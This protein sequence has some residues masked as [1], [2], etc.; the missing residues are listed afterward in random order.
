MANFPGSPQN[1]QLVEVNGVTYR[2]NSALA[3]WFKYQ[4]TTANVVTTDTANI[5]STITS[6]STTTGALKVA[7]GAGIAGNVF[8]GA[9][10]TNNL[11]YA[12]GTTFSGGTG[13]TGS[14]G[15]GFTGS[16]GTA[17]FTGS[18]GTNGTAGFT[19]SAGA[20][21][22]G[23]AGS[24]GYAGSQGPIG[25]TGSAA[26]GGAGNGYTGSQGIPGTLASGVRVNTFT[27]NAATANG[28]ILNFALTEAPLTVNETIVAIDGIVQQRSTYTINGRTLTLTD[29]LLTTETMEV[30]TMVY[31]T[32]NFV[33]R[34][35]TGNGSATAYTVTNGVT[36]NSVVVT[37]NGVVQAPTA[38]YTI[39]GNVLTFTTAPAAGVAIGI[40]EIPAGAVGFTGSAGG[41][42]F[43]GSAGVNGFTGSAGVNGFTGSAG[44]NGFTGSAGA[45]S[46]WS[47]KTANYTAISGDRIIADTT[48]GSFVISLPATPG[49]GSLVKITDGYNFAVNSLTIGAN[50]STIESQA[51]DV[52]VDI[53]KIDL[54]FIYDGSTWQII[55]TMGPKGY[56]GS[57]GANGA[58]GFTGSQG[59]IGY[60]GSSGTGGSGDSAGN[61]RVFGY[62]MIFGG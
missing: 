37:E 2:Y 20:G 7:G 11:F 45:L 52:V 3:A 58:N 8:A 28:S 49:L 27:G 18:A 1:A 36:V 60:T 38:D 9:V 59:S 57:A 30:T 44:V 32:A 51:D 40:R 31:G 25:Y 41:T 29:P 48:A 17:G 23:S 43:T 21:F 22:T 15:T 62:T 50:G 56:A 16:S 47:K 24:I 6:T 55:S 46:N 10:Y 42:G 26:A 13:F 19:G 61:A 34:S 12:N 35:Y 53:G 54:E 4:P 33:N 5:V 39:S 14:A